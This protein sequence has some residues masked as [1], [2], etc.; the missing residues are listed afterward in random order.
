MLNIAVAEVGLQ[1]TGVVALV[2]QGVAAGVAEHV[3]MRLEGQ[4]GLPARPFDHAGEPSRT[5]R[6]PAFGGEHKGRLRFLFALEPP[7]RP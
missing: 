6:C 5:K 2:G 3:G 4:L 1:G 7:Q